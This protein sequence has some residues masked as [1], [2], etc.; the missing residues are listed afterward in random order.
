MK[1]KMI[2]FSFFQVIDHQ[3]N[4]SDKGKP[5]YSEEKP[6]PVPLCPP[7]IPHGLTLDRTRA[8]AVGGR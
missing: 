4:E 5:K 6:V 3:W 1:R 2:S 7:K 8:S